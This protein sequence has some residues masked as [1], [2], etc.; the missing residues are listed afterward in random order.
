MSTPDSRDTFHFGEFDLDVAAYELR[1]GGRPIRLER[2]P[3]DLLILL[4]ERRGMLVSRSEIIDRLW[5]KDV[6]V[7]VETGVHTAVRKIRQA[8]HDSVEEPVFVETISGK[9]YRFIAAVEVVPRALPPGLEAIHPE[10]APSHAGGLVTPPSDPSETTDPVPA[11]RVAEAAPPAGVPTRRP[12]GLAIGALVVA[13]IAALAVWS[14]LGRGDRASRVSLAVLPFENLG[15]GPERDYVAAGLTEETGASLA[16]VD[17]EHL[18][19]KGRTLRHQGTTR[20]LAEV[21]QELAVDFLVASSIRTEGGRLRVTATLIR[22]R[23]QEQVWSETYEREPQSLLGFQQELSS[24]I[25][26]QVR[27]RVLPDPLGRFGGRQT[28]NPDAY[29]AY[30]RGRYLEKR[31]TP[32]TNARAVEEYKRALALDPNYAL[33]WARLAITYTA[34]ALNAD[35]RPL[36][37]GPRAREAAAN[38]ARANP[39]LSEAQQSLGYVYWHLDWDWKAAEAA[40]RRAVELDSSNAFAHG[41]QG[42]VLSQMGRGPEAE[43]L[44]RRARELEPLEPIGAALSSQVAFQA[45]EY[46]AAIEHARRTIRLEANF[47]I[48]P[49]QLAQAYVQLGKF[50]LALE[51]L[52]DAARLSGGNSKALSLRGYV[53]AKMGRVQEA[54]EVF[55]TLEALSHERYVPPYAMALVN[56]GLGDPGPTFEW[57]DK[58]YAERDVHLMYLTVDPKWDPYRTDPRFDALL[59]RCGFTSRR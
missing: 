39:N 14:T 27:L 33:A 20:S 53:L 29:D 40:L 35:A 13:T 44:M 22:V 58:A 31:R 19:V 11:P 5:G 28:Q 51:A 7:D 26:Q 1:R 45:R 55:R 4:V 3:M 9:G 57:L 54:R 59:A 32:E 46:P 8:L 36:D 17:P 42:H 56:A 15:E 34:G 47:W 25:A 41:V 6:F 38:A 48:G 12:P 24:A 18:S 30:L 2:Q 50:D 10:P 52:A 49:M 37:V 16:Q 43:V 23:D 21:G